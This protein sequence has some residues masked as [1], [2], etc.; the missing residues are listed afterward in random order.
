MLIIPLKLA[1][2][3][4]NAIINVNTKPISAAANLLSFD[5]SLPLD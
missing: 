1:Y 5:I 4:P 2:K 3:A